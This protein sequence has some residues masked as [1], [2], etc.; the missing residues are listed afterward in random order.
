MDGKVLFDLV[1]IV[2]GRILMTMKDNYIFS[3]VCDVLLT[4]FVHLFAAKDVVCLIIF[5]PCNTLKNL[6]L[7]CLGGADLVTWNS[8]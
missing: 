2:M 5:C 3:A 4:L 7:C 8:S 6:F 1:N